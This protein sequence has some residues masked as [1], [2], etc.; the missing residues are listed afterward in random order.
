VSNQNLRNFTVFNFDLKSIN[1]PR[2]RRSSAVDIISKHSGI[3]YG[4]AVSD[5]LN[6]QVLIFI[7]PVPQA[8]R[9]KA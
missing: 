1:R 7:V 4:R 8:A 9:S 5:L 6:V 2:A 3:L